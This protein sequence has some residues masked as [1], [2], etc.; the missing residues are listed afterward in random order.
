MLFTDDVG[1]EI[2]SGYNSFQRAR[3][4]SIYSGF[5]QIGKNIIPSMINVLL[6]FTKGSIRYEMN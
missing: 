4:S 2:L 6:P 3:L 5:P 1:D